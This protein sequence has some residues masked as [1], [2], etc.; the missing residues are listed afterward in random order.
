MVVT[1]SF[2]SPLN[3]DPTWHAKQIL[4]RRCHMD[5]QDLRWRIAFFI[6]VKTMASSRR[7]PLTAPKWVQESE[8]SRESN[9]NRDNHFANRCT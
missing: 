4:S 2:D 1:T 5:S 7:Y 8:V 6:N 3:L 9:D